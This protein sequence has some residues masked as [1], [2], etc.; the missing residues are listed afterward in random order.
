[1]KILKVE[2]E[3]INSLA[4]E[5]CID[6]MDPSYS[7]LDH[8]LFVISGKTGVGKTSILDAITLALYGATPRQGLVYNGNDGNAVMTSDKGNCF[9]RVTYRC[10]KGTFVSEWNQ[11][12]AHDKASGN[13]QPA[14]GEIYPV[15]N[16]HQ[17]LFSGRT[18]ANGELGKAN[19]DI[20]QLD[21]S[22]F[23]R[24]IMLAQGEFSKFLTSN[25]RERA[26]ILEKLNGTE[27]YRRIGKKVGDHRSEARSAKDSAQT[28][29]DT[30]NNNMPDAAAIAADEALLAE[31]AEKEKGFAAKKAELESK[32]AWRNSL[33]DAQKRMSRADE[34]LA[35]ATLNKSNFAE[36]EVRLVR[37]E[38][39]RECVSYYTELNGLRNRKMTDEKTLNQ[40]QACLPDALEKQNKVAAQKKRAEEEKLAAEL[41]FA[42]NEPVWNE[43]RKLDENL[44]S[45]QKLVADA[46]MH[47]EKSAQELAGAEGELK[48][49]KDDIQT[50]EP[51]VDELKTVQN[52]NA[53][54]VELR[55]II[56]Q[57]ETLVKQIREFDGQ[58][59]EAEK[60]K[61]AAIKDYEKAEDDFKV[62][63]EKKQSLLLEQQK[64]FESDVLVLADVIQKHLVEG[65]PCPVCGSREHPACEHAKSVSVDE[66]SAVNAAEKIRELNG[67][68]QKADSALNQCEVAKTRAKTAE[69]AAT[70]SIGSLSNQKQEAVNQIASLWKPWTEFSLDTASI[71]LNDLRQRLQTFERVQ[72]DLETL[73]GKLEI[74]RNNETLY[75]DKVAQAKA[76]LDAETKSFDKTAAEFEKLKA[77]RIEKF[78]NKNV[79]AEWVAATSKKKTAM[80]AYETASDALRVAEN[81]CN[82]LKTKI[83]SLAET[84]AKTSEEIES[85]SAN[86][87]N[88]LKAKEFANEA[89]Y[90]TAAMP[91][92][93]FARLQAQKKLLDESLVSSERS[94]LIFSRLSKAS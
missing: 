57:S 10:K 61:N 93:D 9:A 28:A 2:F 6:F 23:C 29:F 72:A 20:I 7:E 92:A 41:F 19:A 87:A 56:P 81:A 39:A 66:S 40:L 25:E 31:F 91:E 17:K 38:K 33:N 15:D 13:L 30:L 64:L 26:D 8:S 53:K 47:M 83:A 78:G 74:A 34:E 27:R 88:A 68:M 60:A 82:E 18:G 59:A 86:F 55:G 11:R 75:K 54:D 4:G 32:I 5:W 3:N 43:I 85:A 44:K 58:I 36:S 46:K 35:K 70:E 52:A 42:E 21:Y 24:S 76:N 16:P 62:L 69:K 77:S 22:Q 65:V 63:S 73:T 14:Q 37:A 1:M 90:L 45:S 48:K 12:R 80:T 79:D 49:A 51:K 67:K 84:L 94:D 71:V 89:D 50:L